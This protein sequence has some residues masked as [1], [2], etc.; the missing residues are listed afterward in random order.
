MVARQVAVL[1]KEKNPLS[2]IPVCIVVQVI[3]QWQWAM[4]IQHMYRKLHL[5]WWESGHM[6]SQVGPL[7][8]P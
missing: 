8:V 6:W 7:M 4:E 3:L 2:F 5:Q 1:E